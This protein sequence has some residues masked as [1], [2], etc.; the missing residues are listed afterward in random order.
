MTPATAPRSCNSPSYGRYISGCN[1]VTPRCQVNAVAEPRRTPLPGR[2]TGVVATCTL[3]GKVVT[4]Q[5][6]A[7]IPS[8][9]T[10]LVSV[11][12]RTEANVLRSDDLLQEG[13]S[14]ADYMQ[15]DTMKGHWCEWG[16]ACLRTSRT[17]P[18]KPRYPVSVRRRRPGMTQ[19]H[20]LEAGCLLQRRNRD[21]T[22]MRTHQ[23]PYV[24]YLSVLACVWNEP[25]GPDVALWGC[26]C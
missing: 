4:R 1:A 6:C 18:S 2:R 5:A 11:A 8:A 10:P 25:R 14:F 3:P 12:D 9:T 21:Q 16:M 13:V 23:R 15:L 19:L 20:T 24:Y 7:R 22:P 26:F 17:P